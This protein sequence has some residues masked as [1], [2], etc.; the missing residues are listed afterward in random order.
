[1]SH[2]TPPRA[3]SRPEK[4]HHTAIVLIPPREHWG[5]IQKIRERYD[6]QYHRWM[7]HI[8]L[9]Y[10][11]HTPA[12]MARDLESLRLA[13]QS[14]RAFEVTLGEL[15]WFRHREQ[16]HTLWLAPQPRQG[17]V[18]LQRALVRAV[19]DCDDLNH[20]TAGFEPHLSVGQVQARGRMEKVLE[21]L[22]AG[23]QPIHFLAERI[24]LIARG[25]PPRDQFRVV[26]E[27]PLGRQ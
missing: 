27:I 10:P 6:R 22:Q 25:E 4:T 14:V 16:G 7:P 11:F 12:R 21:Q 26:E 1:M 23:W 18:D 5:Q 19:P 13:C 20:F 15:R 3:S 8:N 24:S 9:V 2:P 17:L